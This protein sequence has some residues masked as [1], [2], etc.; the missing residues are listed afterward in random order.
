MLSHNWLCVLCSAAEILARAAQIRAAQLAH[1]RI[2]A[3][4]TVNVICADSPKS[5]VRVQAQVP[6]AH[7]IIEDAN[8]SSR[9]GWS[10]LNTQKLLDQARADLRPRSTSVSATDDL[11]DE[12]GS[13]STLSAQFVSERTGAPV[14]M[15]PSQPT[16]QPQIVRVLKITRVS[17]TFA[18]A[19]NQP[20]RMNFLPLTVQTHIIC[21][22]Q[23][24]HQAV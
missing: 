21:N 9:D 3:N 23:G 22:L 8:A 1:R 11:Q 15:P 12:Q 24:C 10:V 4:Q 5:S 20:S 2:V 7:D 6:A 14:G 19:T 17:T 16:A 13:R 18:P